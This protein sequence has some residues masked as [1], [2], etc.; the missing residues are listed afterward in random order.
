MPENNIA[1]TATLP[2][3]LTLTGLAPVSLAVGQ[4]TT[5]TI[6]LTPDASTPL[7]STLDATI[8]ATFGPSAAPQ[9]QTLHDPGERRRPRRG[10]D[11]QRRRSRPASSATPTSPI[12]STTSS[13][14]LTNLVQNPT[15]AVYQGQAL[16]SLTSLISQITNDPFLSSYAAALASAQAALAAATTPD[17][18]QTAVT[19]LGQA[20]GS[21]GQTLRRRAPLR[22]HP[23]SA[24]SDH[25]GPPRRAD[26]VRD[27]HHQHRQLGRDLRPERFEPAIERDGQLQR[28]PRSR[29]S[30]ARGSPATAPPV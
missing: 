12:G 13:T 11:R 9:T 5:E 17:E 6:T 29:S 18:I 1:L 22:F 8:T 30:P 26:E 3:G 19:S 21:L 27:R 28:R 20:L 15:S 2:S 14:A 25:P 16:A 24:E 10:R 7:N 4:S 23:H